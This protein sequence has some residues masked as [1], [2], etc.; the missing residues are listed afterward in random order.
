MPK[1]S[2]WDAND[3][4]SSEIDYEINSISDGY[5]ISII[6]NR[7][8]LEIDECVYPITIDPSIVKTITSGVTDIQC[9]SLQ[10]DTNYK[11]GNHIS[12]GCLGE[13]NKW[14]GCIKC[15][16]LPKL[17][18]GEIITKSILQLMPFPRSYSISDGPDAY[19]G[20]PDNFIGLRNITASWNDDI[21]WNTK[22]SS[23]E[24]CQDYKATS[25]STISDWNYWDITKSTKKWYTLDDPNNNYGLELYSLDE[26]LESVMRYVSTRSTEYPDYKPRFEISYREFIGEEDYW[27]Y[28]SHSAGYKG[29]GRVNNYAGTISV[30][31]NILSY[32]G[33]RNP[34][35]IENTYNNVNYNENANGYIH[36]KAFLGG[37]S[38]SS[39]TGLGFRLSF[40]KL[41]YPLA[42]DDSLYSQGWRYV[43]VDGDGTQHYFKLDG[44]KIVDEDG[45][46]LTLTEVNGKIEIKDLKDNKLTF[47]KPDTSDEAY[48]L[49]SESDNNGNVTTYNYADDYKITS[50]TDAA[51]RI[52]IISYV[53]GTRKVSEITAADG[54]KVTFN[55]D[56]DKL[57]EVFYPGD[58]K[59]GYEYDYKGRISIVCTNEGSGRSVKYEYASNDKDSSNF[60]KVRSIT[61][62]GSKNADPKTKGRST[63][64]WYEMNQTKIMHKINNLDVPY[65]EISEIWQFDDEGRATNVM[66]ENGNFHERE[67]FKKSEETPQTKHRIKETSNGQKI[68]HNLLKNSRTD[69]GTLSDWNAENWDSNHT[70]A[71]NCCGITVSSEQANLGNN[72]FKVS[73]SENHESWPVAKQIV[74]IP[75]SSQDR[76]YTFSAKVKI[77]GTLNGGE[78]ASIHV[79]AFKE[80]VQTSGNEYSLWIRSTD[81]WEKLTVTINVPAGSNYIRCYF[82][83]KNSS[84]NAYFDCLQLEEGDASNE[85]N[86]TE[87]S[88]FKENTESWSRSNLLDSST[89]IITKN[90]MRIT[91]NVTSPKSISQKIIVNKKNPTF[92]AAVKAQAKSV[93]KTGVTD[94]N[95]EKSGFFVVFEIKYL[96][97]ETT[98]VVEEYFN[99]SIYDDQYY[100]NS[101]PAQDYTSSDLNQSDKTVEY[102]QLFICYNYNCNEA[103]IKEAQ[104]TIENNLNSYH[105]N[106]NGSCDGTKDKF[107]NNTKTEF[108]TSEEIKKITRKVSENET[109]TLENTYNNNDAGHNLESQ[110]R[111][112]ADNKKTKNAYT[113]DFVGNVETSSIS[114]AEAEGKKVHSENTYTTSKNYLQT[115]KDSRDKVTT[116]NYD[117]NSGN[118]NSVTN[119]DSTQIS[120]T[121]DS[122][123]RMISETCGNFQNEYSYLNGVLSEISHKVS[124]TAKTTYKFIR[125]IFGNITETKVGDRTLSK[126]I[127]DPG[128]GRLRQ[129]KYGN[130]QTLNYDYD[131][132]GR[133]IKKSFG[134]EKGNKFGE[135]QYTYDNQNRLTQ[136][137]DSLNNLTT[138]FEYDRFGRFIRMYRSDGFSSDVSY[139]KFRN[140]VNKSTLNLFKT[141]QIIENTFGKSDTILSSSIQ[142][143]DSSILSKYN[144]DN[145]E[146]LIFTEAVTSDE[147]SGIKHEISYEDY[148]ELRT[149][150]LISAIEI[151][152]KVSGQWTSLGEKFNYT[153][154]NLGN[155]TEIKDV[156]DILIA[157]YEYDALNQLIRENNSKINKTITYS[158]NEGGNL[159]EKKIYSYTT[160]SDLSQTQ[161]E[162]VIT[163][164]YEDTN[165]P[166]KLTSYNGKDI[167]YD[168][169]GNPLE[170]RDWEFEWSRGRKLDKVKNSSN[171]TNISY[172]YDENGVR[173]QKIVNDVQTDFI[174]SGIKVLAQKTGDNTIIWQFDG[175]GNT[176]GFDYN[177]VQYFYLK[178]AQNDIIGITDASGNI[179]AKY[180][181][182][183]WGKLISITDENGAD[184][185]T[186]TNF[187]G[188]INPLRYRE[189]YYDNETGL[190]YLNARYYDPEL[191][192]LIN[193]DEILESGLNTFIYCKND[194][195]ACVDYTGEDYV[196]LLSSFLGVGHG[197]HLLQDA[198][199]NWHHH[200]WGAHG[201]RGLKSKGNGNQLIGM[202]DFNITD[203]MKLPE[204]RD[205][206]LDT[207][208]KYVQKEGEFTDS[209][210]KTLNQIY[211]KGYVDCLYISGD[212]SASYDYINNSL[213]GI[214]YNLFFNN[215]MQVTLS[216]ISKGEIS[217][218]YSQKI[219]RL[220]GKDWGIHHP[221]SFKSMIPKRMFA[222]M[223]KV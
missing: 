120:Y 211:K 49:E 101:I 45:L 82:G 77:D 134:Y 20:S 11:T 3:T 176:I 136:T 173:T 193:A 168:A 104:I 56:G 219:N 59:I 57:K 109:E 142:T 200:H 42:A 35:S 180:T 24:I 94:S 197:G 192:R 112:F 30:S 36:T 58:M 26:N 4:Y 179:A 127:Y 161:A 65:R 145:I 37:Y 148:D 199:G 25:N 110:I 218:A 73:N 113:Y 61:E 89:D 220:L 18:H 138:K 126:S 143:G 102:V 177:K 55:Y 31:E 216:I 151:K 14:H 170:Y 72:S 12:V 80:N 43:Y 215:C 139:D 154:D 9:S 181:Y 128:C 51:G 10:S 88:D 47:Y 163:Y 29:V 39:Y 74:S 184:K 69:T 70:S 121:Y 175:N 16:N 98:K 81:D 54:K 156:N 22:P 137:Y 92:N 132:K 23:E 217:N 165:W 60:F 189:Y 107:E 7:D 76:K 114:P 115:S 118:L 149:T 153:Y 188:Y 86:M 84:G 111:E 124:D 1:G 28:T 135:I 206:L 17:S 203:D 34:L 79:G 48:V 130:E 223:A 185:T 33:S 178:N 68:V 183:S 164:S 99:Q 2:M 186:D 95:S 38:R 146:R 125:N 209:N 67:Y 190:Y 63:E 159:T 187:I 198:E 85:Y 133:L 155:I 171:N 27:S 66:D 204:N 122:A 169:I 147:I 166:D 87:C 222:E 106:Q 167:I 46:N 205:K 53:E 162:N 196:L 75:E 214:L 8:W 41:V 71:E 78:G 208:N 221:F 123:D 116:Y 32:S 103:Y 117:E 158:Y 44:D 119:A 97:D 210:G 13:A 50:I 194:P 108:T 174:T 152:K 160:D 52:T 83:I 191:G 141:S 105:Y 140:I 201:G 129:V 207:I 172:K 62:Y 19:D 212:S 21:C 157:Q 93:P 5:I 91:G 144:Y 131:E 96:N 6:P 195:I 150:G 40:N 182:D 90:G 202:P 100:F 64:F 213:K 15:E